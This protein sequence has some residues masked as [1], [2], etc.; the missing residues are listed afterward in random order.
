MAVSQAGEIVVAIVG[1]TS[2]FDRSM[3]STQRRVT[4]FGVAA[5]AALGA[6]AVK[7]VQSA[8]ALNES[9]NAVNVTFGES[10]AAITEMGEAAAQ[11]KGLSQTAFQSM[12]VQFSAFAETIAG[13][14]GNVADVID[15]IT[16]RAADFASVMNIDV[17]EAAR[18]FQS[19]L[20]GETEP[21][22]KFGIDLS[23][24][25]IQA[26]A[27]ANG[28]A[29]AGAELTE[30]Q[31]V[32]AR[33]GSLLEQTNKVQG[34]FENTSDSLANQ[35]RIAAAEWEN[36]TASI[37]QGLLPVAN[38]LASALNNLLTVF[39][40]MNPTLRSVLLTTAAL[41]SVTAAIVPKILTMRAAWVQSGASLS[42]MRQKT[43][44]TGQSLTLAFSNPKVQIGLAALAAGIGL[45]VSEMNRSKEGAAAW[46]EVTN[47]SSQLELLNEQLSK[48]AS[49]WDRFSASSNIGDAIQNLFGVSNASEDVR[50]SLLSLGVTGEDVLEQLKAGPDAFNAW[51]DGLL[52]SEAAGELSSQEYFNLANRLDELVGWYGKGAEGAKAAAGI[53]GEAGDAAEETAEKTDGLADSVEKLNNR[54]EEYRT[55]WEAVIG[56]QISADRAADDALTTLKDMQQQLRNTK[57]GFE[58]SSRAAI[59]NREALRSNVE[60]AESLFEAVLK[61]THSR[62][63]AAAAAREHMEKVFDAARAEGVSRTELMKLFP[64][65]QKVNAEWRKVPANVS[66]TYTVNTVVTRTSGGGTHGKR[67]M[68]D[69]GEIVGPGGPRDDN[70]PVWASSGEFIINARSAQRL[71]YGF[72]NRMNRYADGGAV[73]NVNIND[74]SVV[75]R[76]MAKMDELVQTAKD[77]L[78]ELKGQRRE[79]AQNIA[80]SLAG[81]L[82]LGSGLLRD[83]RDNTAKTVLSRFRAQARRIRRFMNDLTQLRRK[84]LSAALVS[85]VMEMGSEEGGT[86]AR[87]L[88]S[89]PRT[90]EQFSRISRGIDRATERYGRRVAGQ[91]FN[92]DIREGRRDLRDARRDRERFEH[93]AVH[94]LNVT[95]NAHP[96]WDPRRVAREIAPAMR[97]EFHRLA[98]QNR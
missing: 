73:G 31:K 85:E 65:L 43:V 90:L 64:W 55:K 69:G 83:Q 30:Q 75:S 51:K 68:A 13:D 11:T 87:I 63:Q 46:E 97:D 60:A 14:G 53:T 58:G 26:F 35:Q 33:Y 5:T 37:G 45:V 76:L 20:A 82:Q 92:D 74:I 71:G 57:E 32:L 89:Q 59:D 44:Q 29:E 28:I 12:A 86:L 52:D 22:R 16:Q 81:N 61:E 17:A 67:V 79:L 88:L 19:G 9:L 8:S 3:S 96:T 48:N 56:V 21:L 25:S 94:E 84:G 7:S 6:L 47:R 23:A 95:V 36:L 77:N 34:D 50:Q 98:R 27:Y 40:A 15:S 24:A 93:F 78:K 66:T 4:A 41:I 10:A 72:L 39:N 42:A 1:D 18:L 2:R 49:Y 54:L 70:I 38:K 80:G 62:R 91:R